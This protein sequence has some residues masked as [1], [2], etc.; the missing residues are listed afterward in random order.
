M[1]RLPL[2]SVRTFAVVARLSSITRAAEELH[3]TPSA[4]SQHIKLLELY[5]ATPL[6][7]REKNRLQLTPRGQEYLRDVSEALAL[8]AGAT[9]KLKS[10][11][12]Q[13]TIR[14]VTTPSLAILWLIPRLPKFTKAHPD[15]VFT[16]TG[17]P[18]PLAAHEEP[19]DVS[20]WYGI[21]AANRQLGE[22]LAPNR[23]FPIC[24]PSLIAGEAR[25]RTP[26]DLQGFTL[27]ESADELYRRA[28]ESQLSWAEWL[29]SAG[30]SDLVP[31]KHL[32]FTPRVL[33][34][35]AVAAGMGVGLSRSLL[36]VDALI[37]KKVAVPFGPVLTRTSAYHV[38]YERQR[39]MRSDIRIFRDWLQEEAA[40]STKKLDRFLRHFTSAGTG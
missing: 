11:A 32:Y 24:K 3:L 40:S 12:R 18:D 37:E 9:R 6:F 5:V 29:N 23:V 34:Q 26:A 36:A 22:P 7:R 28:D 20:I 39:S 15:L 14:I 13:E 31:K 33:M 35:T 27:L 17:V 10:P 2:G 1:N 4:V 19:Y 8:L 38:A 21:T 25:L 16:V 30:A